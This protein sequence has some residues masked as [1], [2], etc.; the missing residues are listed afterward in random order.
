MEDGPGDADAALH[1]HGSPEEQRTQA[2]EDHTRAKNVAQ[3]EVGVEPLPVPV[4]TVDKLHQ[5][6]VDDVTQ[7]VCDHQAVGKQQEG[8]LG[9][10]PGA[11]VGLEQDEESKAV[12]EDANSHGDG[13]GG[14]GEFPLAAGVVAGSDLQLAPRFWAPVG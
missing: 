3:H 12:G 6:A 5:R 9:L 11:G 2:K 1:S 7:Q 8:R 10:D 13:W 14:G 4:G